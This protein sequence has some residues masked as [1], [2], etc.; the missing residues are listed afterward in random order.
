MKTTNAHFYSLESAASASVIV[1]A[2]VRLVEAC[3]SAAIFAATLGCYLGLTRP[4]PCLNENMIKF[5]LEKTHKQ[6]WES[7][8]WRS[9]LKGTS[10]SGIFQNASIVYVL[11]AIKVFLSLHLQH[12]SLQNQEEITLMSYQETM[13]SM[14]QE[15]IYPHILITI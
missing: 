15:D 1:A 2:K 5:I 11:L 14:V 3:H 6:S 9:L 4:D 10:L 8:I 7:C 12:Y 13:T